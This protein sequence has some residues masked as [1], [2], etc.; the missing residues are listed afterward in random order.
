MSMTHQMAELASLYALDA[1]DS[2]DRILFEAHLAE[3]AECRVELQEMLEVAGMIGQSVEPVTPPSHL[4][5]RVLAGVGGS[6]DHDAS[7]AAPSR[8]PIEFEAAATR[9]AAQRPPAGRPRLWGYRLALAASLVL[10]TLA[11][12]AFLQEREA[13]LATGDQL[14]SVQGTLAERDS[15]I[16][17]VLGADVRVARLVEDGEAP[18]MQLFWNH[19]RGVLV[20]SAHN[21]P[22]A[23][24]G[25]VYQLWGIPEDGAPVSLGTF[26]TGADGSTT[27][28]LAVPDAPLAV[29]AVTEEP[30]GGSLQPTSTPFLVG[31]WSADTR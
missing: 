5:E 27:A 9:R 15:L 4:R 14:R 12:L 19:R 3:C 8:A 22:P 25:R 10:A 29:S 24:A 16:A 18:R 13:R 7:A 20:L 28:V 31:A 1:L 11:G 26:N 21:L 30:Q 17:N 23:P 2:E 6:R